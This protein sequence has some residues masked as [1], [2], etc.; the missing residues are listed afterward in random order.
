MFVNDLILAAP[1]DANF[2]AN[3][4]QRSEL[5]IPI[6]ADRKKRLFSVD[7]IA[8]RLKF[9]SPD[10]PQVFQLYSDY[11]IDLKLIADGN[12]TLH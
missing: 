7:R 5:K 4:N 12:Y 2:R 1:Y 6:D 9:N 10:F 8:I 11:R 3:G